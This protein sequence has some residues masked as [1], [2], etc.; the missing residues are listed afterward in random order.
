MPVQE[1]YEQAVLPLA[2]ADRLRLAALILAD[3]SP[4]AVVDYREDWS[5]ED[6]QDFNRSSWLRAPS[7]VESEHAETW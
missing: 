3:I 2:V 6:L 5:D 7:A 4:R 1:F